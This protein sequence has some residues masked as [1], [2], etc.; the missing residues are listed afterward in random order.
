M[1]LQVGLLEAL[2]PV[3]PVLSEKLRRGALEP[4][5]GLIQ[6]P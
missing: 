6:E 4:I 5:S 1:A 3:L 2:D